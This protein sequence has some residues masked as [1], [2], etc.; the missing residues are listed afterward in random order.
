MS[1]KSNIDGDELVDLFDGR[2]FILNVQVGDKI[3]SHQTGSPVTRVVTSKRW[4]R[5][6]SNPDEFAIEI[7]TDQ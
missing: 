1:V 4:N 3:T 7:L 6:T 5:S 2:D